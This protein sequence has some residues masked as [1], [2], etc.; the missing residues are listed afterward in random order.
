MSFVQ[1]DVARLPMFAPST[2]SSSIVLGIAILLLVG[3][4]VFCYASITQYRNHV[5]SMQRSAQLLSAVHDSESVVGLAQAA[6]RRFLL[7]GERSELQ[8]IEELRTRVGR[9]IA[10]LRK[11]APADAE[12]SARV[13]LLETLI[14]Q[15]FSQLDAALTLYEEAGP[16]A[17]IDSVRRGEGQR[18][19]DA[20]TQLAD[21]IVETEHV[22]ADVWHRAADTSGTRA[23]HAITLGYGLSLAILVAGLLMLRRALRQRARAEAAVGALNQA[24]DRNVS[25]LDR[26]SRFRAILSGI[27][28]AVVRVRS[29]N[30]LMREACRVAVDSGG[31]ALA[32]AGLVNEHTQELRPQVHEGDEAPFLAQIV[33][34]ARAD[35]APIGKGMVGNAIRGRR[36]IV[37]N[38]ILLEQRA[39]Y[40]SVSRIAGYRAAAVVPFMENGQSAG[41]YMLY[42]REPGVFDE[43]VVKLL[44]EVGENISFALTHLQHRETVDRLAYYDGLTGLPNAAYFHEHVD[45]LLADSTPTDRIPVIAVLEPER[46]REVN[47]SFGAEAGD[48]LL[49]EVARR[50]AVCAD[51]ER[52]VVA[53]LTPTAFGLAFHDAGSAEEAMERAGHC[54]TRVTDEPYFVAHQ[55]VRLTAR[56]GVALGSDRTLDAATLCINAQAALHTARAAVES[57]VLYSPEMNARIARRLALENQLRV[58]QRDNQFSV[59]YQPRV[60]IAT[61]AVT[62]LEALLRWTPPHGGMVAPTEFLPVLEESGLVYDVGLWLLQRVAAD[63][64][65]WH[66][67][68]KRTPRIAVNLSLLQL[69][70]S[71]FVDDVTRLLRPEEAQNLDVELTENTLMGDIEGNSRTLLALRD[72]GVQVTVDDFGTG[73]SSLSCLVRLPINAIKI[74]QSFI[75]QLDS[76]PERQAVVS[77]IVSLSRTLDLTVIAEGVE[78]EQQAD[79]LGRL[80]CD[81]MQGFFYAHP[82]PA[83]DIASLLPRA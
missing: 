39:E 40:L 49:K 21:Q 31:F 73:Y 10:R 83:A 24:L 78:T 47:E 2:K 51:D 48:A 50:I 54:V 5:A 75:T 35:D 82:A 23:L 66:A 25:E 20:I 58:A 76:S 53:R 60:N 65:L 41:A 42:S 67:L 43:H 9:E 1:P 22:R 27:N 3:V 26:L 80:A 15:R 4:A 62:G 37:V 63:M 81:E 44:E 52:A 12:Q 77:A 38:D 16:D 14:T 28:Q 18:L 8:R 34:S 56:V 74:D 17:A 55:N 30:E 33:A 59:H 68:G 79:I 46:L 64:R 6:Q 13:A 45:R 32:W 19:M 71:R 7:L 57:A 61:R 11:H 36:L 72:L 70:D 29:R 69:S